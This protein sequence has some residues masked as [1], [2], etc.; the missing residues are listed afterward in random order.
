MKYWFTSDTHFGHSNII[1]YTER[2][3]KSVEHMD[4]ELIRRWNE[5]VNPEDVVF[6][7]GDFCF[8][9]GTQ[10]GENKYTYYEQQLNGKII[11]IKGNHDNNNSAK[12]IIEDMLICHGGKYFH[13][14]HRPEDANSEYNLVGHIHKLWKVK[15]E[16]RKLLINVGVDVHNFYPIDITT[17]MKLI[18][19][20]KSGVI[21]NEKKV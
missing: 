7:L 15:R 8:K 20:E 18:K 21:Q 5:R 17:I 1:K 6:H 13:L 4:K 9:G 16:G 14:V 10:G 12:T 3:F 11:L 2:P 19:N